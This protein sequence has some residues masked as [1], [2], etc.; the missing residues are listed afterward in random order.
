MLLAGCELLDSNLGGISYLY[1]GY[2]IV[3]ILYSVTRAGLRMVF[4]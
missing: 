4:C 2:C 3:N 1:M